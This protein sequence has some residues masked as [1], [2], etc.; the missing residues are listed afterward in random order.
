MQLAITFD[1]VLRM[2][3]F[4]DIR[5]VIVGLVEGVCLKGDLPIMQ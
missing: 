1:N 4:D 5:S 3:L 2:K